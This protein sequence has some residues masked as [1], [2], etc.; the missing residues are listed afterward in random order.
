[1]ITQFFLV[2]RDYFIETLPALLIGFVLSG[3]IHEFVPMH[4]VKKWLGGRGMRPIVYSTIAGTFLPLCCVGALPVAIS[5]YKKGARL[6]PVLAFLVATPATSVT[7]LLVCYTFLGTKFTIFIFFAV[8]LMG[9]VMGITGNSITGWKPALPSESLA[10][11]TNDP[12]CEMSIDTSEEAIKTKHRDKIY[13]FCSPYCQA[14]FEKSPEKYISE[15]YVKSIKE[16]VSS[17]FKFAFIDMPKEIG[18][19]LLLGLVLAA[20]VSVIV[21]VGRVINTYLAGG[22]GYLFGLLFGLIMYICSTASVPLVHAFIS[23][24]MN[25]G[26]G[27]VLLIAGPVT[28]Y[29]TILLL[30]KEFGFKIL[31][32]Y[33]SVIAIISLTLGYIFSII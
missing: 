11:E 3:L 25:I 15:E 2:F 31:G 16:K 22:L 33:L 17:A 30:R 12:V 18:L 5:F 14:I 10:K 9:V 13:Y 19:E 27:M 4:W 7:A 26:A 6:G 8:I 29:A 1:M 32:I 24:G 21:P 23:Q 28:S 20:G